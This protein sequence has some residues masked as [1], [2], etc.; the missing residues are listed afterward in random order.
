MKANFEE[1]PR[2]ELLNLLGYKIEDVNGKLNE[3]VGQELK[4]E[5][6][7]LSDQFSNLNRVSHTLFIN[8]I[9]GGGTCNIN[10]NCK[11]YIVQTGLN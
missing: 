9:V 4:Q 11:L 6:D 10:L 7:G 1:N 8:Q 2:A 5:M 3:Y